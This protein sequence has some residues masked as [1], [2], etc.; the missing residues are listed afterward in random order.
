MTDLKVCGNYKLVC[1]N[2]W[3]WS[4]RCGCC[5]FWIFLQ[6]FISRR[7]QVYVLV[8]YFMLLKYVCHNKKY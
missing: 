2:V 3:N 1:S 8:G 4:I 5:S 6:W 7:C